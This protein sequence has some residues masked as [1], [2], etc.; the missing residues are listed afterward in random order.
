MYESSMYKLQTSTWISAPPAACFDLARSID[1]HVQSA[2]KS[3]ERVAGGKSTGLL[4]LGDEVTW[5]G[6]HFGITQ[7]MSS[8]ITQLQ[9]ARFFQDRMTKG[10]FRFLVHDHLFEPKDGGTLMTDVLSFQ[11]PLGCI[12]WL[13]ERLLLAPHLRRFLI[14]RGNALKAMAEGRDIISTASHAGP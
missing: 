4:E 10:S 3:G 14:H 12:G 7:R 6:R 2:A 13:A 5:E 8:R 9:P 1:A 11:A